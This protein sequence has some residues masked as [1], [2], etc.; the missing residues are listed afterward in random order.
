MK[1]SLRVKLAFAFL[2][3]IAVAFLLLATWES[4]LLKK[5][6]END[7]RDSLYRSATA[8]SAVYRENTGAVNRDLLSVV[9]ASSG[10]EVWIMNTGGRVFLPGRCPL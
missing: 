8:I 9:S 2:A 5:Q 6:A 7:V 3:V 10:A 1:L 4:A